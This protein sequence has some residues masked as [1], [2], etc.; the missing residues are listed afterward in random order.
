VS[1]FANWDLAA[2]ERAEKDTT[3]E[4]IVVADCSCGGKL[5]RQFMRTVKVMGR[6]CNIVNFTCTKGGEE[7]LR[8]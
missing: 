1:R 5:T 7:C 6:A 2:L 3:G 8:R 4:V